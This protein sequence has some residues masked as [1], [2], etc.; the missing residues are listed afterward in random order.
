M[1]CR[2][3][4]HSAP[5]PGLSSERA[6]AVTLPALAGVQRRDYIFT[7]CD[8]TDIHDDCVALGG[9]PLRLSAT[10]EVPP[11]QPVSVDADQPLVLPP[12]AYGWS[13]FEVAE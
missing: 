5:T 12:G 7:P 13:W 9:K 3:A 4:A 8:A 11:L 6:V 10:G 1:I 2:P